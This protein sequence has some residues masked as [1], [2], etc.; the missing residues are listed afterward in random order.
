MQLYI[1]KYIENGS[2][3]FERRMYENLKT[4]ISESIKKH[5][6]NFVSMT[7]NFL[8]RNDTVLI[9]KVEKLRI[10]KDYNR[11]MAGCFMVSFEFNYD[12]A[13]GISDGIESVVTYLD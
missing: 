11:K 13:V 8:G 10:A 12:D 7:F 9:S 3:K 5:S 6:I 1:T 4:A 2:I